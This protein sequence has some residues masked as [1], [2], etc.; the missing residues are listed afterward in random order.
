MNKILFVLI[1]L[2]LLTVGVSIGVTITQT[3]GTSTYVSFL[4]EV[5]DIGQICPH[6]SVKQDNAMLAYGPAILLVNATIYNAKGEVYYPLVQS[7]Q[8]SVGAQVSVNG[9]PTPTKIQDIFWWEAPGLP[10]G[11]YQRVVGAATYRGSTPAIT[12]THFE[13]KDCLE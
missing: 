4:S 7:Y 13:I 9:N 10:P 1:L 3:T 8:L 11:L 2:T 5:D 6:Q 12:T